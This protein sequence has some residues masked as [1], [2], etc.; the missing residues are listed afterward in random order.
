MP[1]KDKTKAMRSN[2]GIKKQR[3]KKKKKK[4]NHQNFIFSCFHLP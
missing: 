2:A 3:K 4:K 1:L